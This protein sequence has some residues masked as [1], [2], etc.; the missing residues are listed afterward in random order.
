[1]SD[2]PVFSTDP[3][4]QTSRRN[5]EEK[6]WPTVD[7]PCRYRLEKKGRGGKVVSV[8]FEV[9]F[10]KSEAKKHMKNLQAL[11]GSGG[12]LKS[13]AIELQGDQSGHIEDY[14]GKLGIKIVRSGS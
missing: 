14:F 10:S 6:G 2:K 11:A 12:T 5:K 1:M 4:T 8:I 9:T 7:G 13:G 3:K